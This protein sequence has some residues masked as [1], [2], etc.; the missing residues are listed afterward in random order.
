MSS[1]AVGGAVRGVRRV[2]LRD[3]P[4]CR[5]GVVRPAA[6]TSRTARWS[7]SRGRPAAGSA[8]RPGRP[9]GSSAHRSRHRRRP[10]AGRARRR[11]PLHPGHASAR[12]PAARSPRG[13]GPWR[14]RTLGISRSTPARLRERTRPADARPAA[15]RPSPPTGSPARPAVAAGC[16]RPCGSGCA[17]SPRTAPRPGRTA[18]RRVQPPANRSASSAIRSAYPATE[19]CEKAGCISRRWRAWWLP[20]LE[21]SPL[22]R[23]SASG[24]PGSGRGQVVGHPFGEVAVLAQDLVHLGRTRRRRTPS[25]GPAAAAP[26][27]RRPS[28]AGA[29]S[30]A[31]RRRTRAGPTGSRLTAARSVRRRPSVRRPAR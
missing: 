26:P 1:S 23:A 30:P 24:G 18:A 25:G 20:L 27:G 15:D 3:Q 10:A 12:R 14:P 9:P 29:G 31:G 19:E 22:P 4:G 28:R 5:L 16:R 17:A 21:S 13:P 7:S 6:R 2:D 11:G 8:P